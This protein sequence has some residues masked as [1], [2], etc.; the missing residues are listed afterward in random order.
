M[1]KKKKIAQDSDYWLAY[2]MALK[3]SAGREE[4]VTYHQEST[5][6]LSWIERK[7]NSATEAIEESWNNTTEAVGEAWDDTT[8]FV[9]DAW[10]DTTEFVGDAWDDTTEFVDETI[11]KAMHA[12]YGMMASGALQALG[13]AMETKAGFLLATG[14]TAASGGL[15]APAAVG[16][17]LYL[18]VDGASNFSGGISNVINGWNNYSS[19]DDE[20][21]DWNFYASR[22]CRCF[23]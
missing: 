18:M 7:W 17:G 21:L 6:N 16:G 9:G 4:R 1:N 23:W 3:D 5:E 20:A 19:D 14:G 12:D 2:E 10:D 22:I 11:D 15:A 8:E 13:G